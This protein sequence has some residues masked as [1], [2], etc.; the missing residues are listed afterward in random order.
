MDV[1]AP[2]RRARI[3]I[4]RAIT[5]AVAVAG[6]VSGVVVAG[7]TAYATG[8]TPDPSPTGPA[9]IPAPTTVEPP[10]ESPFDGIVGGDDLGRIGEP[11]VSQAAPAL[12][13]VDAF[14]WLVADLDTGE[15]LAAFSPHERRPPA[16]TIKIL[17]A[18]TV[19][20]RIDADAEYVADT[21]PELIEGSRAG[22]VADG[23]YT[24][25]DLLHGLL[26]PSG[27]DAAYA[28]GE[29]AGG[30]DETLALMN[31]TARTLGAFDTHAA[32]PH[33][34]DTPGQL[35]SAYDLALIGRAALA[36]DDVATIAQTPT[37][38]F[39]GL[40]GETFQIQNQNRLLGSY[41]GAFGLKTGYTTQ[42]G[43]T[44]VGAAERDGRRLITT[45]L[46]ADGRAED[47][48]ATLLDWAFAATA[49]GG[50]EPVG[51]LVTPDEVEQALTAD[52]TDDTTDGDAGG[53]GGGA[54][55]G[56]AAD[57]VDAIT[58]ETAGRP[59]MLWT[60][61]ASVAVAL[62]VAILVKRRRRPAGRY[63]AGRR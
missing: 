62:T 36:N 14:A 35:S 38:Q 43:H 55:G 40:D 18:I 48:A 39:P 10:A 60:V 22:I 53:A 56:S 28:L 24:K 61:V 37:Y 44:F 31:E 63:A 52:D 3:A 5:G 27:N 4:P 1:D 50:V 7:H 41:D 54:D 26:L 49:S 45:V 29:L 11:V 23:T 57:I 16:S 30:Q 32:T 51:H 21:A 8:P 34:L 25:D 17:T 46:A 2:R 20:P 33:G 13:E 19:A 58:D 12:P 9:P 15:V 59:I 6:L 42:A 47:S